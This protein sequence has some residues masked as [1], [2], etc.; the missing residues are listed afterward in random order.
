[1]CI[2]AKFFLI[3]FLFLHLHPSFLISDNGSGVFTGA[4]VLSPQCQHAQKQGRREEF[5]RQLAAE[6]S[7]RGSF[8]HGIYLKPG[9]RREPCRH[10]LP[11]PRPRCCPF[12]SSKQLL[13]SYTFS[14]LFI[15][16]LF[17]CASF[18]TSI[19]VKIH[20]LSLC[21]T[22]TASFSRPTPF[23]QRRQ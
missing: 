2:I 11:L 20:K 13:L 3:L 21:H 8:I 6:L 22:A 10:L 17:E 23:S 14:F 7:Q 19:S 15:Q 16:S 4:I 1:M 9:R 5:A 18:H 12:R